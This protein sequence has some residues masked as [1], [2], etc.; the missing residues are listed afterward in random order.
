M[1]C[2]GCLY[3]DLGKYMEAEVFDRVGVSPGDR[4]LIETKGINPAKASLKLFVVPLLALFAGYGVGAALGLALGAPG[5]SEGIG[6]AGAAVFFAGSFAV[7][8]AISKRQMA[9]KNLRSEIVGV[10]EYD[11]QAN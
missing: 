1:G 11:W 8:H 6:I 3:H 7:L 4:V 5:A 10:L 2:Q 9:G